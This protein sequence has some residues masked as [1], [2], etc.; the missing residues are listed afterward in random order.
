MFFFCF[1]VSLLHLLFDTLAF[2]NDIQF[3]KNLERMDGLSGRAQ[4]GSLV[5]QVVVLAYLHHEESSILVRFLDLVD[6]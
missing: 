2:K 4:T 6:A 3:W 1:Q 5:L